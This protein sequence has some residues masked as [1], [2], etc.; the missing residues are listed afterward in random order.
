MDKQILLVPIEDTVSAVTLLVGFN[1]LY[2]VRF[3]W[4][5]SL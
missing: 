1:Q 4:L 3:T 5:T 2:S